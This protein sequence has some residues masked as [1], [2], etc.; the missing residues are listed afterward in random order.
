MPRV[1]E[2]PPFTPIEPVT[3]VLHGVEITDPYRWLEDQNSP[4]TRK[5]LE[6]QTGYTRAYLDAIPG[7]ERIRK[8][9]TELLSTPIVSDFS[10][11][12]DRHFFLK[13]YEGKQQPVIVMREGLFGEETILV[14]PAV[15]GCGVSTAASIAAISADGRFLAYLV[16]NGGTDHSALEILDIKGNAVFP[17]RLPQG[18]CSGFAFAPDGTGFFY[19][20][21]ELQDSRPNYRAAFWHRFGTERSQDREVF[22]AGEKPNLFLGILHSP[23][24]QLLAF[25]VLSTGKQRSTSIY[26]STLSP[27]AVPKLLLCG[28]D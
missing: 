15:R 17:D 10:S 11:A 1:L 22:F 4:R 24:A 26:L 12:G 2:P 21:R 23:N 6:E 16:R 19:S 7:R 27:E 3:E 14:D 9:V 8:R 28:I 18:Y 13:R 25:V 5:W 20:H